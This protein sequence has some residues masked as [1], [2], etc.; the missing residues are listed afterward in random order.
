M[1]T[2]LGLPYNIASYAMLT[3]ML[4]Q[5]AGLEVGEL[6]VSMGDVHIYDNHQEQTDEQLHRSPRPLPQLVLKNADSIFDYTIDNFEVV[7]YDAHPHIAGKVA[8]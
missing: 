1:D 5:Q 7:G 3:H 8:V 2:F 4:A 6:I